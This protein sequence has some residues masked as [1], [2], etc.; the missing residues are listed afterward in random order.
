VISPPDLE[1]FQYA[2]TPEAAWDVI[3]NFYHL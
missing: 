3:R 1:L 2:D